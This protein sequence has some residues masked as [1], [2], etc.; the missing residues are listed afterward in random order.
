[1]GL[2]TTNRRRRSPVM[3]GD[4]VV[5]ANEATSCDVHQWEWACIAGKRNAP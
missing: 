4:Y 3:A 5:S 2:W 1:M